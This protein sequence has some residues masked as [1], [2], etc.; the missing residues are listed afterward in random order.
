MPFYCGKLLSFDFGLA[1]SVESRLFLDFSVS[2]EPE[3]Y[4]FSISAFRNVGKGVFLRFG[5]FRNCG[6]FLFLEF[7]FLFLFYL[8]NKKSNFRALEINQFNYNWQITNKGNAV[9]PT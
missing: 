8:F 3:G 9:C 6:R 4:Y 5:R 7:I 1:Q 2:S